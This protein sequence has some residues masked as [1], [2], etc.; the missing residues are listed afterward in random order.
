M[1]QEYNPTFLELVAKDLMARLGNELADVTVVFPSIRAGLFFNNYLVNNA[2]GPIWAPRYK[3]IDQVFEEV[4]GLKQADSLLL[5]GELYQ[6]YTEVYNKH[7]KEP[8]TETLDEFFFFGETLLR[9]FDE[10]D[11]NLV[12]A[13]LLFSNLQDLDQLRDDFT[14]LNDE[15]RKE[16]VSRFSLS[17][18][19]DEDNTKSL[20]NAF[21]SIWN[22]LGEVYTSFKERLI[23]R[24]IAYPGM[25]MRS[26]IENNFVEFPDKQYLFVGFNVL[27]KCEE[28][29]FE[30]LKQRAL[31]Y[32]DYD[33][34][35]LKT[36]AGRYINK[37][38]SKFGSALKGD[39]FDAFLEHNTKISFM[40]SPSESAQT[41]VITPWLESLNKSSSFKE[42]DTAIILCNENIL[43]SAMHSL[44]S[45][46]VENIN[47]TMGFPITQTPISSFLQILTEMQIHGY[48][49]SSSWKYKYI[50]PVLRHPYTKLLFPEANEV[51]RLI[52][53]NNIFYPNDKILG[54]HMLFT[55]ANNTSELTSYLLNVTQ[56]LG[57]RMGEEESKNAYN[58]LY[59]E[60]VFRAWQVLNRLAGLVS[61]EKWNIEKTT[62][63]RLLRKLLSTIKIPFHGEPVQGLQ[64]M[65]VLETR[66]LD[67]KNILMLSVNEGFMP[68]NSNDN[69]FIP[70]FIREY[71]ELPTVDHQ[72][73]IYAYYFYRLLQR[74][75]NITLVYN[76]D[77]MQTGKAEISRFLLQLLIDPQLAGR[78]ER[79]S[80]QSPVMP[81]KPEPII[82]NKDEAIVEKIR[83]KYD[84][85]SNKDAFRLSPTALNTYISCSFKF[86]QQYIEGIKSP[87]EMSDELD[88]SVF[89]SIF[90]RAAEY[91]YKE[92]GGIEENAKTFHS[93]V[94]KQERLKPY[95]ELPH[96]IE[97][98]VSRAFNKEYFKGNI[99][100]VK[101]YDGQQLI[102]HKILCLL[103]K[104]LVAFDE[105]R[106]P[107]SIVGLEYPITEHLE[108]ETAKIKVGGIIDRLDEKDGTYFIIDYK[109]SGS[110]K[111]YKYMDELFMQKKKRASHIFQ[112]FVYSDALIK[113]TNAAYP[114]V[115]ALIYLQNA[116]KDG[117]SP[118]IINDKEEI[119]D[120]RALDDDFEALLKNK[121]SEL[122]D[123][124]TPFSQTSI[125]E[126]CEYCEF[127]EMCNR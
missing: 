120:F 122:F 20:K 123:P 80:L 74:A 72:D 75:E 18:I 126:S 62:M 121:I 59:N 113:K 48:A 9:D 110:A 7:S 94:V 66:A 54:E 11:K 78:I 100:D 70:Q 76:T 38:I 88:N 86:Y 112:T 34:Y 56:Q 91:L 97:K 28:K 81:W 2:E 5:V 61:D 124:N 85:N 104:R 95:L 73:S 108:L 65:G 39:Y 116:G 93:F 99:V 51:E 109:S 68:G 57:V 55:Y 87:D 21:M 13:K 125:F 127:K 19:T 26:V 49:R 16:L 46:D 10:I 83:M 115:P 22:I 1:Q 105:Q 41:A 8:N 12:N 33:N 24:K 63:L 42:P 47:I 98:L 82:V 58:D 35:Y 67:F 14:H 114:I 89:G 53:E 6:V 43:P 52:A 44:P 92:I 79:T 25:L 32:W 30:L 29:L 71:F 90:H 101:N 31:F 4:A 118:I 17:F 69:S 119:D 103:L 106:A 23:E 37:N 102:K 3:S 50:M 15:Q 27:S 64:I 77:K 60:S 40:A 36:E 96:K 111:G 84:L 117:Y 107:F 45:E